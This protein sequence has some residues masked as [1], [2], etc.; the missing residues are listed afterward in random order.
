M[1]A[2]RCDK[3]HFTLQTV[4]ENEE[5]CQVHRYNGGELVEGRARMTASIKDPTNGKA[6]TSF[7]GS[8]AF[9][10]VSRYMS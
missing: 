2:N 8:E 1:K 10:R 4:I 9:P 5:G 7:L 6:T 3:V